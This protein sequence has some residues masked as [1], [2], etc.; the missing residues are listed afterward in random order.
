[1]SSQMLDYL[2]LKRELRKNERA[3]RIKNARYQLKI[4]EVDDFF[5]RQRPEFRR[6]Q[7][8]ARTVNEH[9]DEQVRVLHTEYL[10][11]K[12]EQL[13]LPVPSRDSSA[14]KTA[15]TGGRYLNEEAIGTLRAAI[16]EEKKSRREQILAWL[17]AVG[18]VTG[19]I[20]ALIGLFAIL[21]KK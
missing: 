4:D 19:I 3:R 21:L 2:R 15:M 5:D 18:T 7:E 8:D 10:V 14:W 11:G 13:L 16:R 17:P 9:F 1:M 12:A 6:L 20:G